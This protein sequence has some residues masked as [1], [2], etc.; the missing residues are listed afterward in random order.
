[1]AELIK[2]SESIADQTLFPRGLTNLAT[3]NVLQTGCKT[4]VVDVK[5]LAAANTKSSTN[6]QSTETYYRLLKSKR[7]PIALGKLPKN[8]RDFIEEKVKVCQPDC[9]YICD[10]SQN[11]YDAMLRTLEESGAVKRLA[12]D[13]WLALT[14]P[15]DVARV[16][17]RT[18]ISTTRQSDTI[19]TPKHG[20]KSAPEEI[21]IRGL[22]CSALGNWIAPEDLKYELARRL[23]GCMRGR[24]MFVIVF[25]MGPV[26]SEL[27][28]IGVE[29]TDSAYVVCSM[30]I[31][32]RMGEQVIE[33]MKRDYENGSDQV[34]YVKCLHSVGVPLPTTRQ[35]VS[36]WPCNP[37]MTI[38]SHM[39]ERNEIISYG[40]G[41]GGNSLLGKKCFAL[42]LGSIIGKREGWLAEHMLIL[43]ITNPQ[44]VK[45]YIAAA[46]P[47]AC[48]KTNLAMMT[49]TLPGWKVECVGDDIA[50]MKF[51]QNGVLRAINPEKGF[52]GVCPGTSAKT[53][54]IALK[55][56][57]HNT[58]FTN[59]A[60]TKDGQVYWEGL[61]D[62]KLLSQKLISW[63]GSEWSKTNSVGEPAAHPNSRFCAPIEQCPIADEQWESPDGV[64]ISAILF[65]GRRPCGVPLVYEAYNWQH[66]VLIGASMRSEA[67]AAAEHKAKTLMHDPF[68][69]RPFFGYNFGDYLRHWLSLQNDTRKMPKIFHV[70][71]FRRAGSDGTG[72]FLWPGFGENIRVLEWIFN[73]TE[74]AR[75][76]EFA[77]ETPIGYMPRNDGSF[78]VRGLEMSDQMVDELFELD[79]QFWM[80]EISEIEQYFEE[81]VNQSMPHEIYDQVKQLKLRF[82]DF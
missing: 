63:K 25:S 59:V 23:P 28:K 19:P 14:D 60:H 66:G 47:S 76:D 6:T 4:L 82:E 71:W 40:S 8:V 75:S 13:N 32:T 30:R 11:E 45:K 17:S 78:N 68:A 2:P 80:R 27:S 70:N 53:N 73:R 58:I 43:G 42:R 62:A 46:F 64:P 67:T 50:W 1:M 10:G 65:G 37:E 77:R 69:M 74:C 33:H 79:K 15:R 31:M 22:K 51:D 56:I 16:E 34:K 61:D 48:G 18:V 39:P 57:D 12:N 49:P 44:G 35:I 24:T 3:R 21:N 9:V 36:N 41:Y 72:S 81:N 7:S 29:L 54:P 5:H 38:V 52:F 26:G 55:T 20:F